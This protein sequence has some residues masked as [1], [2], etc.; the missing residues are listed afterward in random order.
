MKFFKHLV[1]F[2]TSAF[3]LTYEDSIGIFLSIY[4]TLSL[5]S[6]QHVVTQDQASQVSQAV[7]AVAIVLGNQIKRNE[8]GAIYGEFYRRYGITSYK[9]LPANKFEQVMNWLAGWY[10]EL[11]NGAD[12]PF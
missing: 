11:T 2:L 6:P 3:S 5:A 9:L 1:R 7:K 4:P 8:S 12:V 10:K